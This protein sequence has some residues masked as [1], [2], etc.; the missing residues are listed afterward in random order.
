MC[1]CKIY[2][3]FLSGWCYFYLDP[4]PPQSHNSQNLIIS[5]YMWLWASMG[6]VL[7]S[8]IIYAVIARIRR[9]KVTLYSPYYHFEPPP[10]RV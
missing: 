3:S 2:F 7:I 4:N 5:Y 9:K 6:I 8:T 10:P 1:E